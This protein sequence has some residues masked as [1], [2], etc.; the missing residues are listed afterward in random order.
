[1]AENTN[2]KIKY[3]LY[4]LHIFDKYIDGKWI[5]ILNSFELGWN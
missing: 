2:G 5:D 1:M 3:F 4:I